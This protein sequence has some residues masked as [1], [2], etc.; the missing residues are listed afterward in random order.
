MTRRGFLQISGLAAGSTA[1]GL[2]LIPSSLDA[3]TTVELPAQGL[4]RTSR[5]G[6]GELLNAS[7]AGKAD[8]RFVD[9]CQKIL[10]SPPEVGGMP[11]LKKTVALLWYGQPIRLYSLA[12]A[13]TWLRDHG[14]LESL[15]FFV[16]SGGRNVAVLQGLNTVNEPQYSTDPRTLGY[17][18]LVLQRAHW[19]GGRRQL[20]TLFPGPSGVSEYKSGSWHDGFLEYFSK[21]D[22]LRG[23]RNPRTFGEVYGKSVDSAIADRTMLWHSGRGV[24]DRVAWN[25]SSLDA[26]HPAIR[27][28]LLWLR[29]SVDPSA[30]VYFTDAGRPVVPK[31]AEPRLANARPAYHEAFS[32]RSTG[33]YVVHTL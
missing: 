2:S 31:V 8:V 19:N 29:E 12:E 7:S 15:D 6:A 4:P 5:F 24:F 26:D 3:K 33:P 25:T 11:T 1:A 30:W 14:Y 16:R 28:Q 9:A 23:E 18:S 21:Y 13:D 20:Y 27:R 32:F 10:A 22:M 17:L